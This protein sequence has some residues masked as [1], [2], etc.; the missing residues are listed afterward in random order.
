MEHQ[1]PVSILDKTVST[2]EFKKALPEGWTVFRVEY[3]PENK[4]RIKITVKNGDLCVDMYPRFIMI[5]GQKRLFKQSMMYFI[6]K[7]T[8]KSVDVTIDD[9]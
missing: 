5:D 8:E 6:D 9:F 1:G 4:S 2:T 3:K 7:L